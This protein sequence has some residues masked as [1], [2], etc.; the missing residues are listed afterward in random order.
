MK[1]SKVILGLSTLFFLFSFIN[2]KACSPVKT[3]FKKLLE[4][5]N[6]EKYIIV[7]GYFQQD[8]KQSSSSHFV[9]TKSSDQSIKIKK[10]YKVFEYG[11]FGSLCEMY[12]M[13]SNVDSKIFGKNNNRLLILYKDRSNNEKLVTPIFWKSGVEISNDRIRE[14]EYD[15][16]SYNLIFNECTTRLNE[17]W[18]K[19]IKGSTK[20]L[21]W[22][23]VD[24]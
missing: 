11:P 22:I 2:V 17:L 10:E 4:N 20:G 18:K 24:E 9:V 14:T 1:K 19:I 7:E 21:Q 15:R 13:E 23:K 6:P 3:P 8:S 16:N 5:Y 12:E